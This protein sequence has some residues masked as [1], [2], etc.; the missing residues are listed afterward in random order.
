MNRAARWV[1]IGFVVFLGVAVS[2]LLLL[3]GRVEERLGRIYTVAVTPF[4]VEE[5]A[6]AISRGEHLVNYVFFC[7]ECHGERLEGK[8][9][10]NDPLSG[11]VAARNLT[12][13]EGGLPADFQVTDWIRAVRHGV[14][15]N[16]KPLVEMPSN[17]Y[18]HIS[19]SDLA[20]IIAYV[21]NLPPVD[22]VMPHIELGP[23]YKLSILSDPSLL[24]AAVIDHQSGSH[25]EVRPEASVEYGK[26][27]AAACTICHGADLAGGVSAGAG[28]NL[29]PAGDLGEWSPE[30][31]MTA[32]RTGA[33]PKGRDLDSELMPIDRVKHMTDMELEAL[34][35]YLNSLPPRSIGA[36]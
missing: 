34:W 25:P 14:G 29:T 21:R 23:L 15:Q 7:T 30:E 9:H 19:D 22:N 20:A 5:N 17:A 16:G 11:Q 10:F 33:T 6:D 8:A 1:L 28:L 35:L 31:F 26:Y 3:N 2:A 27:L 12:S 13:G 24:P 36:D 32:V 4:P 18:Q